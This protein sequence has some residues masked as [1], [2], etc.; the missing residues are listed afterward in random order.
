MVLKYIVPGY[1]TK[2]LYFGVA[3]VIANSLIMLRYACSPTSGISSDYS[4]TDFAQF[5]RTMGFAEYGG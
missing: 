5:C 3:N 2:T 4:S 1:P